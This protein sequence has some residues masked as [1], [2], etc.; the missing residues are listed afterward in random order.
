M[1]LL[2]A[3]ATLLLLPISAI[4]VFLIKEH[5]EQQRLNQLGNAIRMKRLQ[6]QKETFEYY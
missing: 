5:K 2:H 6:Q 1:T 4:S 3:L